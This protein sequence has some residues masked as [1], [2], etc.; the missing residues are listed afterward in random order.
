M[1]ASRIDVFGMIY[2]MRFAGTKMEYITDK[3][4][5][6]MPLSSAPE[7]EEGITIVL[8][9]KSPNLQNQNTT[10]VPTTPKTTGKLKRF[11]VTMPPEVKVNAPFTLTVK[12]IDENGNTLTNYAGAVYFDLLSGAYSDISLSFTD[13]GN[14]FAVADK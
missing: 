12:A 1:N 3:S 7:T 6:L 4:T 5:P 13:A 14:S 10:T 8:P 2:N 11:A 9:G